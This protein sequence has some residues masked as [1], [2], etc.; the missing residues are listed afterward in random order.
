MKQYVS[1]AV[2]FHYCVQKGLHVSWELSQTCH[3]WRL[4]LLQHVIAKYQPWISVVRGCRVGLTNSQGEYISKGWKV[5]TT[6]PLLAQ[7]LDLLCQC[8]PQVVH[9]PCQGGLTRQTA[10]YTKAFALRV[11]QAVLQDLTGGQ[12]HK[13]MSGEVNMCSWFGMG[14]RCECKDG[15]RHGANFTC[16]HCLDNHVLQEGAM[17]GTSTALD[18]GLSDEDVLKRLH[19]LHA[20]TGHGSIRNMLQML[21]RRGVSE[22]VMRLAEGFECPTCKERTRPQPRNLASLEPHPERFATVTADVAHWIHPH[23][24]EKWQFLVIADEASRFRVAR[25]VLH[26][27]RQHLSATQFLHTFAESWVE[28][29]GYPRTLRLDPDGSFRSNELAEYCDRHRIHL[30]LIPGEAH[31]KLSVCERSIQ[32]IKHI[33]ECVVS[34]EPDVTAESALAEAVRCLNHRETVR[35]YSPVQHVLG[36]APDELGRF[37][38]STKAGI[39]ELLED[40]PD[41]HSDQHR[42]RL[43]AEKAFLDWTARERSTRAL[44]SRH[45]PA[46]RYVEQK[47]DETGALRPGSSV[48][49]VRGRR[50]LKCCPEQLRHASARERLLT[51]LHQDAGEPGWDFP[52]VAKELGGNEYEDI[53]EIPSTEEWHR[54]ADG[55]EEWQPTHRVHGKRPPHQL[56]AMADG[57]HEPRADR[58]RSPPR[59]SEPAMGFTAGAHWTDQVLCFARFQMSEMMGFPVNIRNIRPVINHV[60]GCLITDSRNVYDK[61]S[62]EVVSTKG[63]AKKVDLTLM[64]IKESQV[65]YNLVVRWVHSDAQLSN[66]LTKG[67]ELR[68]LLL[69]F[70]MGQRWPMSSAR[71][72]KMKG[73][74]P[75]EHTY[76]DTVTPHTSP[77]STD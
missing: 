15:S 5:M 69:F 66:S 33:L 61:V 13:E 48:W 73:Q 45:R 55:Q 74:L 16:G 35:G 42:L 43:E 62:A 24:H 22:R 3:A 27:K 54:A 77:P 26:G 29:F 9:V 65:L 60:P 56:R 44:N 57:Q 67:K 75:L 12:V 47:R 34:V 1:C 52:T 41:V 70:E 18:S 30:D 21:K 19:L 28:Y 40:S 59:S 58:S 4:P 25:L 20:A 7:R 53:Q 10:Y 50:L 2:I 63:A 76:T 51:E 36:R 11:C 38:P 39:S 14:T 64:R 31:W 37:F 49:V 17:V 71:K 32:S 72:R 8:G 46:L 6:H 68:Q 23:T